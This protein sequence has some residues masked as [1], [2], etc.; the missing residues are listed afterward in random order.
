MD[1]IGRYRLYNADNSFQVYEEYGCNIILIGKNS[2]EYE[3]FEYDS[4]DRCYYN[5][6]NYIIRELK[7]TLYDG[8]RN[9]RSGLLGIVLPD[10]YDKIYGGSYTCPKCGET[11][12]IVNINSDT[13]IKEFAENYYLNP[14]CKNE[15]YDESGRFCVLVKYD[16]FIKS[17][18]KYIDQAYNKTNEDICKLVHWR[19]IDHVYKK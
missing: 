9:R 15:H 1:F 8:E 19:D 4:L 16:D 3:G 13:V 10:M 18:D 2:S 17:P 12:N 6:Q 14:N 7:A 11:I 5:K